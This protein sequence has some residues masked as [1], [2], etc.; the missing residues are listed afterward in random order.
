[1]DVLKS[2]IYGESKADLQ[3]SVIHGAGV[4][5]CS[6][7]ASAELL[8]STPSPRCSSG[9]CRTPSPTH[10]MGASSLFLTPQIPR[11]DGSCDGHVSLVTLE[12]QGEAILSMSWSLCISANSSIRRRC[13][14]TPQSLHPLPLDPATCAP[15]PPTAAHFP[16]VANLITLH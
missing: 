5:P 11:P 16:C 9:F 13:L 12:Q 2:G 10:G 1:M 14:A 6:H 3:V 15:R 8:L 7:P 4:S